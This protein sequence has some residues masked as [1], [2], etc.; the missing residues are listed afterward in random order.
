[1]GRNDTPFHD[2]IHRFATY[3]DTVEGRS[4]NTINAY[5]RDLRDLATHITDPA[6]FTLTTLRSWLA[7]GVQENLSRA[8]LARRVASVRSFSTWAA[9][10]NI[11]AADEAARLVTPKPAK[12]LPTVLGH[13]AAAGL[14]DAANPTPQHPRDDED[15]RNHAEPHT[16]QR[17]AQALRDQAMMELLYATGMR[18]AELVGLNI[19]DIDTRTCRATVTGKGNKQRTV[20]FGTP[21]AQAVEN[22]LHNGRGHLAT[23]GEKALFVGVRGKRIDQRQVRRIVEKLAR[24]ID[25]QGLTPHGLRHT[26]A[27]H[28]LDGG[29]D[30]T[31]VQEV[32][33]HASLN[34]TQIYTHVSTQRL[35]EAFMQAHP[36]AREENN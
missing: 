33:G 6:D 35:R 34:T 20:P 8:T 36:R 1:M 28:L 15:H 32:L 25:A 23:P 22:W 14:I 3:L 7:Q 17:A 27:T 29:A 30:L 11:I 10:H 24:D 12:T 21:A 5:T 9:R 26:A 13:Q 31:T 16:P 18:V 2:A 4:P 19:G